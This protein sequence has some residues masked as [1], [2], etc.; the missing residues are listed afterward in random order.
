[1][2]LNAHA[3]GICSESIFNEEVHSYNYFTIFTFEPSSQS[4]LNEA[5]NIPMKYSRLLIT[6][7]MF[8]NEIGGVMGKN[9]RWNEN[10]AKIDS[11][12]IFHAPQYSWIHFTFLK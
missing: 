3:F 11:K 9:F 10:L 4:D 7:K 2:I 1:M 5:V 12:F 6:N 8:I